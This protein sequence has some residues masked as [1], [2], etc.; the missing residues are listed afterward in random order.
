MFVHLTPVSGNAKTGP[1]PVSTTS[2]D[3][4]PLSCPFRDNGCYAAYGPLR[5]HWDKVSRGERGMPWADFLTAIKRLRKGSLWRHNQAGDLPGTGEAIDGK[6]LGELTR[7]NKGRQGFT[8]THKPMTPANYAFVRA[9]NDDGFAVNASANS[10]AEA[11]TLRAECPGVPVVAVVS[12][13]SPDKGLTP[14][15]N[16]FIVCP[17]QVRDDVNCA[18][19]GLCAI[20][21]ERRPIIAFRAHG[22]GKKRIEAT[23]L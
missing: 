19:C 23:L 6:L 8:Y 16:K 9:A 14:A 5:L 18:T 7:A 1:I 15:G 20:I 4:C 10:L 21:D 12:Q 3:T 2:A 13:S 22:T 17:A 11:D